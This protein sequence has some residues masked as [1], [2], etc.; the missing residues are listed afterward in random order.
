MAMT[1]E[2]NER[3]TRVGPG[4]PG[5]ELLRRYWQPVA[6]ALEL[7]DNPVK[8]VRLLGED[9]VLYRTRE[10]EYGLTD[11][12]CPHRCASMEFGVP[13]AQGL[14]CG[15]HGWL[16]DLSGKCV[17]APFEDRIHPE[18][19]FK[20]KVS[21]KA[22]PVAELGGL[23]FAY[24]GPQPA[25]LLPRWDLLVRDDL[26]R[27]IEV[28]PLPCNWVQCMDNSADPVHFEFLHAY[29]GNYE[30]ERMGLPPT[31]KQAKHLKIDFDIFRYGMMKRR[32]AEGES[33][34]STEWRI[35][36]PLLFPNILA[37]G[38][39]AHAHLQFRVAVDDVNTR[40]YTY[41]TSP[42]EAGA[43]PAPTA[44]RYV[45][46]FDQNRR[47]IGKLDCVGNQDMVAWVGQGPI[48]DRTREHLASS[49][50]GVILYHKL[51][52]DNMDRV[53]NGEEPIAVIRDPAENEPMI[54]I[55]RGRELSSHEA[56]EYD[57]DFGHNY[58]QTVAGANARQ[59][60]ASAA[61]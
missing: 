11:T 49:D 15:Y 26:D 46:M 37:V 18:A 47:L 43:E 60:T 23:L 7:A 10:G 53:A 2:D 48:S 39:K 38:D 12:T 61:R 6:V 8:L 27:A 21:I 3:L 51:L 32:L 29:W 13:E 35:G 52:F 20:D 59:E 45:D 57:R 56:F 31:M 54:N 14:R 36:H 24:L 44:L 5:G 28:H 19:R 1:A 33:E 41:W 30:L 25:P 42:R 55:E 9:L 40:N 22:Y 4:T 58:K 34:E 16:F 50:R 17:E